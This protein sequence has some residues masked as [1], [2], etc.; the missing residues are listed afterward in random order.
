MSEEAIAASEQGNVEALLGSYYVADAPHDRSAPIAPPIRGGVEPQTDPAL[1]SQVLSTAHMMLPGLPPADIFPPAK[2][3]L[4]PVAPTIA[5]AVQEQ[6]L[7]RQY[8]ASQAVNRGLYP[9][10]AVPQ[11]LV[12]PQAFAPVTQTLGTEEEW[13]RTHFNAPYP[14]KNGPDYNDFYYSRLR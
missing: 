9:Q 14:W 4:G 10:P 8:A 13:R 5:Q 1:L 3:Q 6:E 2:Q 11:P 12:P 7:A